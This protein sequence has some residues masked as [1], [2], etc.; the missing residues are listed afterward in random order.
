MICVVSIDDETLKNAIKFRKKHK[1]NNLSYTDCIGYN[2]A[3]M[4][5]L[6]F[7]TGDKEFRDFDNVEFAK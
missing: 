2:Y 5:N 3:L 4:H 7:L 1:K 6:K